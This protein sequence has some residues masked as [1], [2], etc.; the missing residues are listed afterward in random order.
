MDFGIYSVRDSKTGFMAPTVDPNDDAAARN[1]FHAVSV[2]EGILFTY[3]SDFDLY[4]L[5]VFDSD[6]G[7]II[8]CVPPLFIAAGSHALE[9]LK[10]EVK[11]NV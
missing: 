9:V 11:T 4:K 2:S 6:S 1:F 5:G 3:A 8:P 10:K 7:A